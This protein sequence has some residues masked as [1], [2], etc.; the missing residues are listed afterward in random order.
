MVRDGLEMV[1]PL[2]LLLLMSISVV[3]PL[4]PTLFQKT[5]VTAGEATTVQPNVTVAP[6]F[7][8]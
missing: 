3:C 2:Y 5:V 4:D 8:L 7:V 1:E 6:I